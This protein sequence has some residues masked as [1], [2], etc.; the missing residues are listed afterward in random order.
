LEPPKFK[1][2]VNEVHWDYPHEPYV[3]SIQEFLGHIPFGDDSDAGVSA[4]Q[5]LVSFVAWTQLRSLKRFFFADEELTG[6]MQAMDNK[7]AIV[8][9]KLDEQL[10]MS[11]CMFNE[12]DDE[13]DENV[14]VD[15]N[16]DGV[17]VRFRQRTIYDTRLKKLFDESST[18]AE[19][20]L[21]KE[22]RWGMECT[23]DYH[24][25]VS[26]LRLETQN[27]IN[28][29][30]MTLISD[31]FGVGYV[32]Q[33]VHTRNSASLH[34]ADRS[35]QPKTRGRSRKRSRSRGR[36]GNRFI[37]RRYVFGLTYEQ[38]QNQAVKKLR[39]VLVDEEILK[40]FEE[41]IPVEQWEDEWCRH[42]TD[43]LEEELS[44]GGRPLRMSDD[45]YKYRF[46]VLREMAKLYHNKNSNPQRKARV[47]GKVS[48]VVPPVG[49]EEVD[50]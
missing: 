41:N 34:S 4:V 27:L 18:G 37:E 8:E 20:Q 6:K 23:T 50:A 7:R 49:M 13:D 21:L 29:L 28:A 16:M 45:S 38:H 19:P 3:K 1:G 44:W 40:N 10:S 47:L 26:I 30:L 5:A 12:Q 14:N 9:G 42:R 43:V 24:P 32:M 46:L 31:R 39:C 25:F 36:C 2:L 35:R 48:L 33:D 15:K 22:L 11:L 17:V